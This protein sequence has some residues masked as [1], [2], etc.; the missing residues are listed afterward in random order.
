MMIPTPTIAFDEI[1]KFL[2]S[3]PSADAIVAYQ[4]PEQLQ[5]RMHDLMQK[6]RQDILSPEEEIELDEF[7]R[8]NRFMSRLQAKT[9]QT[10]NAD[11][12]P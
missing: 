12:S 6:N 1:I 10:L 7:L 11:N 8:M 9:K 5:A 2:A 4:P 3:A